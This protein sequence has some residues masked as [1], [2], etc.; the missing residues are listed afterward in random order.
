MLSELDIDFDWNRIELKYGTN[1]LEQKEVNYH[2]SLPLSR[3]L[4]TLSPSNTATE[5][6]ANIATKV[7]K[8]TSTL[9]LLERLTQDPISQSPVIEPIS[10]NTPLNKA[11]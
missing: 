2:I 6:T 5:H 8:N 9:C 3:S 10:T 11:Y 4:L 1:Q 7:S